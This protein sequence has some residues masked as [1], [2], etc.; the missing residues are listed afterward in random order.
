MQAKDYGRCI[1]EKVPEI[2]QNMCAKEFLALRSCM[3][4]VVIFLSLSKQGDPIKSCYYI[5]ILK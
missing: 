4:T 2:E 1:A 5:H 3:Q